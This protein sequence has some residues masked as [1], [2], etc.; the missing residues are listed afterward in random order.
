MLEVLSLNCK[1]LSEIKKRLCFVTDSHEFLVKADIKA[2]INDLVTSLKE[3]NNQQIKSTKGA[4]SPSQSHRVDCR[5]SNEAAGRVFTD[6]STDRRSLPA[7]SLTIDEHAETIVLAIKRFCQN[8]FDDITLKNGIDY[9]IHLDSSIKIYFRSNTN[10]FQLSLY[11]KHL[12]VSQ[13]TMMK[14]KKKA[15]I[16]KMKASTQRTSN[17]DERSTNDSAD[18]EQM[19][20]SANDDVNS[21]TN[22]SSDELDASTLQNPHG[23]EK[24]HSS[25]M[26]SSKKKKRKKV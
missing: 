11:F 22:A 10:S 16:S 4:K 21:E 19:N 17:C 3:K 23:Y 6:M 12:R 26:V 8:Q 20:D 15:L 14:L 24:R 1:E 13:C 2:G 9:S 5:P 7:Q 25:S 18:I